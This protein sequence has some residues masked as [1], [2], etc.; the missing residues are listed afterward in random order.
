[1]IPVSILTVVHVFVEHNR[2]KL[3]KPKIT[4]VG[5]FTGVCQ[6]FQ[7]FSGVNRYFKGLFWCATSYHI[8]PA[9]I[10]VRILVTGAGGDALSLE[11]FYMWFML[12]R[13]LA[14]DMLVCFICGHATAVANVRT[15]HM[16]CRIGYCMYSQLRKLINS[17]KTYSKQMDESEITIIKQLNSYNNH[18]D[19]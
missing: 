6:Y 14:R 10:T 3:I 12:C 15:R 11:M 8:M 5:Y 2:K 18:Q 17:T 4:K 16:P 19:K 7:L 13:L 1:M 9:K